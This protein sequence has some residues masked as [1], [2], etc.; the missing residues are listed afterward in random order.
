MKKLSKVFLCLAAAFSAHY[1]IA[2]ERKVIVN[3]SDEYA[4]FFEERSDMEGLKF[5][6]ERLN[7]HAK[8]KGDIV[9]I[10]IGKGEGFYD[11]NI[12]DG[13]VSAG[14]PTK[15]WLN[16]NNFGNRYSAGDYL[17]SMGFAKNFGGGYQL[18][19]SATRGLP[20]FSDDSEDGEY[21]SFNLSGSKTTEYGKTT[22]GSMFTNSRNGG[23]IKVLGS[24][25]NIKTY[26]LRHDYDISSH[27]AAF[28]ELRYVDN[29]A[30]F[31]SL[32]WSDR[33]RYLMAII[34]GTARG[35]GW[36]VSG[37]FNQG[38]VGDRDADMK[39][40]GAYN[41][42]FSFLTVD[43]DY[44]TPIGF[45]PVKPSLQLFAPT[46]RLFAGGQAQLG[47]DTPSNEKFSIGGIQRGRSQRF[48]ATSAENGF[49]AG[50]E[51][52]SPFVPVVD[53][54]FIQSY[55]GADAGRAWNESGPRI[56]TNAAFIGL[57]GAYGGA[58][59]FDVGYA[60]DINS[61]LPENQ[62][63]LNFTVSTIF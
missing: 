20:E 39:L 40:L 51:I 19:G 26:S 57:R 36:N 61:D 5:S 58:L 45:Y 60:Y 2:D 34:G 55:I 30:Q 16:A 31:S 23:E 47:S 8:N 25:S 50:A 52:N 44:S 48:G 17:A 29:E 21:Y 53:G 49:Y 13:A 27:L 15:V 12:N 18:A 6:A 14:Q 11:V 28:G 46:L 9:L 43:A 54:L 7:E 38:V 4:R 41:E 56:D 62:G 10:H 35:K 37:A 24:K 59:N 3:G 63:K 1:A 42:G 33:E 32:S 22:L